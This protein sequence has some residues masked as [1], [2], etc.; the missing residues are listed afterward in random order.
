[1][2]EEDPNI[3]KTEK[4]SSQ[5]AEDGRTHT[6]DTQTDSRTDR[7]ST[8]NLGAG[9]TV[10]LAGMEYRVERILSGVKKTGEAVIC[11]IKKNKN[12]K[13]STTSRHAVFS[14]ICSNRR[15]WHT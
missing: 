12:K 3:L 15:V 7:T 6:Y 5:S 4:Y 1:M 11:M 8:H 9:D 2:S 10:T 14:I 13:N